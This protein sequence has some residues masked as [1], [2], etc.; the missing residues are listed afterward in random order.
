M[1]EQLSIDIYEMSV[2][3]LR[4][5]YTNWRGETTV[6]N[7]FPD[8]IVLTADPPYHMKKEWMMRAV[9]MD[10]LSKSSRLYPLSQISEAPE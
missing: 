1:T 3:T 2:D 4:V 10:D 8:Q 7:L 5:L 6:R 9:D